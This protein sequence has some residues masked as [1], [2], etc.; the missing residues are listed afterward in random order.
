MA[1]ER[2]GELIFLQS[3][4]AKGRVSVLIVLESFSRRDRRV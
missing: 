1:V 2:L 3:Q 4:V